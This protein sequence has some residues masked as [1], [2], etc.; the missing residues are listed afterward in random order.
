[1]KLKEEREKIY[2]DR[3]KSYDYAKYKSKFLDPVKEGER[4]EVLLAK[5][6]ED[7]KKRMYEKKQ[8]YGR[9]VK[10]MHKPRIS[11]KKRYAL[12]F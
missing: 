3:I 11:E 4:Q 8:N 1:M 5:K 2:K 10:E 6:K 12:L 9:L 7:E